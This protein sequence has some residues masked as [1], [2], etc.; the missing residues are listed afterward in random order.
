VEQAEQELRLPLLELLFITP[1]AEVVV[2]FLE[3]VPQEQAEE[4]QGLAE[5]VLEGM[6]LPT[7]E[8]EEVEVQPPIQRREQVV[9]VW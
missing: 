3:L 9:L 6:E 4:E 1:E 5:V 8:E 2:V 7:Q